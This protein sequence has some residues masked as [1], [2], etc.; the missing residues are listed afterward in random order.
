LQI[1]TAAAMSPA[2]AVR[3]HLR[4]IPRIAGAVRFQIDVIIDSKIGF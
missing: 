1:P 3:H 2:G 4:R